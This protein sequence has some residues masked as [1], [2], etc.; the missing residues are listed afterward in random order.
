LIVGYIIV[1]IARKSPAVS[2]VST[3][4]ASKG[5]HRGFGSSSS[6]PAP[7]VPAGLRALTL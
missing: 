3:E 2:G 6:F 4:E 1:T 5:C 7:P